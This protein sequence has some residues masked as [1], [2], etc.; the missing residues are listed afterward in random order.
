MDTGLLIVSLVFFLIGIGL[1]LS[2]YKAYKK[3][4]FQGKNYCL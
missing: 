1:I 4:N 2:A 3:F